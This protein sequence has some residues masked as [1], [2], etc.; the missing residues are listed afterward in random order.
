MSDYLKTGIIVALTVVSVMAAWM[1]APKTKQTGGNEMLQQSL[2]EEIGEP[3][4]LEIVKYD[5]TKT[6]T[7]RVEKRGQ[8][9]VIPSQG[10]YPADA[11][12]QMQQA[13]TLLSGLIINRV[14]SESK[15]DA[16]LYGVVDP[17][18]DLTLGEEDTGTKV[19]M[20]DANG[21]VLA[22][23]IIGKSYPDES[24]VAAN[25]NLPEMHYVRKPN[26][27]M[28][29]L[30]ELDTK[31]LSTNF[32]DWIDKNLLRLNQFNI[33]QITLRKYKAEPSYLNV[34]TRKVE[35]KRTWDIDVTL[36]S[37]SNLWNPVKF[38]DYNEEQLAVPVELKEGQYIDTNRVNL[39]KSELAKLEIEDVIR[40]PQD[41]SETPQ[42]DPAKFASDPLNV[43]LQGRGFYPISGEKEGSFEIISR[44]GELIVTLRSGVEY[45]LRFGKFNTNVAEGADP[46][47]YLMV[48]ARVNESKFPMPVKEK[49]DG[50]EKPAPD[51]NAAP[52]EGDCSQDDQKRKDE[53]ERVERAY[54]N[55]LADR[56]EK[57]D[58]ARLDVRE[59][60]K[61]FNDWFYLISDESA[62]R[63]I[64]TRDEIIAP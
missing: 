21:T 3:H 54:Q 64:F 18:D 62:Q 47:R 8:R 45:V 61:R 20:K 48:S 59:L 7:F 19:S 30:V 2:F 50:D 22:E 12:A 27:N 46:N 40:K 10:N 38:F 4:I 52:E 42:F 17:T 32:R 51:E 25:P 16:K 1:T 39:I 6:Q 41:F 28:I 34:D 60:N 55:A 5:G 14:E 63:L 11:R 26:Q 57:L 31:P 56:E 43:A 44:S 15:D 24:E 49:I 23:L 9:F 53:L 37:M 13:A 36:K 29:Y 35:S 58:A 33:E